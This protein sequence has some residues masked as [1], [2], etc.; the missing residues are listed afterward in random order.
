MTWV[1]AVTIL[2]L[3]EF[4]VMGLMVSRARVK[5]GVEAPATSG[6]PTFERYFR[7]HQN[8]LEALMVFLPGV[9]LFARFANARAAAVLGLVFVIARIIYAGG[10]INEPRKRGVGA[11]LTFLTNTILVIGALVGLILRHL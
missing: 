9:W 2:A 4:I 10:Y 11:A 5:Y 7:V 1:A 6:H 8:T 3:L